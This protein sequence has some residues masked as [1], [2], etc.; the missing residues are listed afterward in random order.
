[1]N[2]YDKASWHIDEGYDEK[3]VL[4][5]FSLI[6]SY[7]NE[8]AMLNDDGKE[9]YELGIDESV[10]IHEGMLT[11]SGNTFMNDRYD[12]LLTLSLDKLKETLK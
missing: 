8:N 6:L 2:I 9:I 12:Y 3:E 1:M 5:R 11:E 7:L 10:V 4:T